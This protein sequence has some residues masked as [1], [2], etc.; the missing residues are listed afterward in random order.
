MC[1]DYCFN[2][3]QLLELAGA[4]PDLP[5]LAWFGFLF[6]FPNSAQEPLSSSCAFWDGL[7]LL[8]LPWTAGEL[9]LSPAAAAPLWDHS[10]AL[11]KPKHIRVSRST[12]STTEYREFLVTLHMLCE[13]SLPPA[14]S[15]A[16]ARSWSWLDSPFSNLSRGM[17]LAQTFLFVPEQHLG[18]SCAGEMC[19]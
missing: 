3:P 1:E 5:N 17:G 11:E 14:P 9:R 10:L 18:R 8:D 13:T 19:G 16:A 2:P 12:I 15:A 4:V 7:E 6:I